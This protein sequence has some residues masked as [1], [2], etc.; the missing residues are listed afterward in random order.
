MVTPRGRRRK[1][2]LV[3]NSYEQVRLV[4][5]QIHDVHPALGDRTRGIVAQIPAH[6]R[7]LRRPQYVL[8][9]QVEAIGADEDVDLIVFPI[10]ALGRG[11]NIV[12]QTDDEDHGRAAIGSI[13]F[14]TRPHPAAGDLSLMISLLARATHEMD[15]RNLVPL[16][17]SE[18]QHIYDLE[19]YESYRAVANLLARPMSASA[20]AD[21]V[22]V[23]FAANQL[24]PILQTI[25][26]GMRKRMP[27]NVYF[28]DAAWAPRS[29]E[30]Q[31]ETARSSLLVVMQN[32]LSASVNDRDPDLR[33]IYQA[34]YGGFYEAFQ[35]IA[36][37]CP[38]DGTT[39]TAATTF[40]PSAAT[41]EADF[42]DFDPD[43]EA[44]I[45]LDT[46]D[47]MEEFE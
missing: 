21:H 47:D 45:P 35:N 11:V 41:I 28:V 10:G 46:M 18:V 40:Q 38:P 9:G 13:Y 43:D 16:P 7:G 22:L 5:E 1:A 15:Q 44:A 20:L 12:F 4:V 36:E 19:R 29:A 14:L 26:R 34:L 25:G 33:D 6:S 30:H 23:N 31:P 3:V 37:L 8:K 42:D 27:V 2:A 17:L 24:V 39:G 32:I